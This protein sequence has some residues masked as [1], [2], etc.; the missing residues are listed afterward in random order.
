MVEFQTR[1]VRDAYLLAL[2]DMSD[3]EIARWFKVSFQ[4]YLE[5]WIDHPEFAQ[6]IER[7]AAQSRYLAIQDRFM[8]GRGGPISTSAPD[9][10]VGVYRWINAEAKAWS[11]ALPVQPSAAR[12]ALMDA[13]VTSAKANGWWALTDC[14]YALCMGD[15]ASALIN[16]KSPGNFTLVEHGTGT[17][18]ANHGWAGDGSTGYLDSQ[19][20]PAT[21]GINW[22]QNSAHLFVI[23]NNNTSN[24][25]S[26][27]GSGTSTASRCRAR[28]AGNGTANLNGS[29]AVTGTATTITFPCRALAIRRDASNVLYWRQGLSDATAAAASAA[30]TTV[31]FNIGRTNSLFCDREVAFTSWGAQLSDAQALALDTD[32]NTFIVACAALGLSANAVVYD[33]FSLHADGVPVTTQ[34]GHTYQLNGTHSSSVTVSSGKLIAV[35]PEDNVATYAQVAMPSPGLYHKSEF[36]FS[37]KTTDG[38]TQTAGFWN[39]PMDNDTGTLPTDSPAHFGMGPHSWAFLVWSGGS[40]INLGSSFL[41]GR[42]GHGW[43]DLSFG[44]LHRPSGLAGIGG[45][46]EGLGW[47]GIAPHMVQARADRISGGQLRLP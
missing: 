2:D 40:S 8:G 21:N 14:A 23:A 32:V 37:A 29:S 22:A 36:S 16:L 15:K 45:R 28:S 9:Q 27:V 3:E 47:D 31:D 35:T 25:V 11:D 1:F 4:T 41:V 12:K 30:L 43:H 26:D 38:G 13:L 34:S 18:T 7:G 39:L 19:W 5:W 42:S 17:F 10:G 6:A 44:D 24:T 20:D 33:D 46:D